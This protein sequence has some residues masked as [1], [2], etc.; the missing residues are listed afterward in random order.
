MSVWVRVK[1]DDPGGHEKNRDQEGRASFKA[2]K[3]RNRAEYTD[4]PI[5][6]LHEALREGMCEAETESIFHSQNR[7]P[8]ERLYLP[9]GRTFADRG[10]RGMAL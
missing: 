3:K 4:V 6:T 5:R 9:E 1:A 8:G 7:V 2:G 10:Q